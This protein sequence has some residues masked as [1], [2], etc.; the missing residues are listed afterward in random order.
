MGNGKGNSSN[1]DADEHQ[2]REITK[3]CLELRLAGATYEDIGEVVGRHKANVYRRIKKAIQE[4]PKSDVE[5]L[6]APEPGRLTSVVRYVRAQA[7][8]VHRGDGWREGRRVV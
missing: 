6:R 5:E 1:R 3:R 7:Q 2:E 8:A 4:I